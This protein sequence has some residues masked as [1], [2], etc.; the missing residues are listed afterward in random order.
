MNLADLIS[1]DDIK[2]LSLS[3][4][5]DLATQAR[6]AL[7]QKAAVCG[8]HLGPSLGAMELIMALHYVFNSPSLNLTRLDVQSARNE[9]E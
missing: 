3:E 2:Q 7:I 8:G 4:L 5:K 9:L 1:P 6:K